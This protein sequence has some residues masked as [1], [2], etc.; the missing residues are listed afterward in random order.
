MADD[1]D[2]ETKVV[3]ANP[4]CSVAQDGK[5]VEDLDIEACPHYGHAPTQVPDKDS[6]VGEEA[7][8]DGV[9]LAGANTLTLSFSDLLAITDGQNAIATAAGITNAGNTLVVAGGE[10]DAVVA[11]GGY[12]LHVEENIDTFLERYDGL[13]WSKRILGFWRHGSIDE[14]I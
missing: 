9:G 10:D 7:V 3:C 13:H 4:D 14:N 11:G 12:M 2:N 6:E 8:T 1:D 5:C